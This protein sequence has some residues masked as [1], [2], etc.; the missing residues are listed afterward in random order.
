MQL[1]AATDLKS[2]R[3]LGV[4]DPQADIRLQFPH[5]PGPKMPACHVLAFPSCKGAVIDGECHG[6]CRLAD[7]DERQSFHPGRI[8]DCVADGNIFR[9]VQRHDIP[10]ADLCSVHPFQSVVLEQ[11]AQP[12]YRTHCAGLQIRVHHVHPFGEGSAHHPPH[13]DPA[14][15]VAV[16]DSGYQHLC[17]TL[18][19]S[20][21]CG[22]IIQDCIKQRPQILSRV[23][24]VQRCGSSPCGYIQDGVFD[25]RFIRFQIDQ[26][27]QNLIDHFFTPGVRPVH[28]VDHDQNLQLQ[29]QRL[30]QHKAG[31]RHGS[32]KAVHQQQHAVHHLQH[33]FDLSAEICMP[34]GIDNVNFG[35]SVMHGSIFTQNGDAP[36]PFQVVG[37][38][39]AVHHLLVFSVYAALFQHLI[40][41]GRLAMIHMC[42]DCNIPNIFPNHLG[43]A[44]S[45]KIPG[46]ALRSYLS[47]VSFS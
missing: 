38:H 47:A 6:H 23:L 30:L 15:V 28:L 12:P 13:A 40:N 9:T 19:I 20:F 24:H 16:I 41:Q 18:R 36:L 21:R 27:I 32:F 31:L 1:P 10:H 4:V 25:R 5:Q 17:R 43:F 11:P 8:A 29:F 44:S 26:Q 37:I 46:H 33:P 35:F 39:H 34:G 2:V 45:R 7:L 3:A 22:N 14:D 42:N